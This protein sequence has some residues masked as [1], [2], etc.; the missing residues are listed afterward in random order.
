MYIR[1]RND[2]QQLPIVLMSYS[3]ILYYFIYPLSEL[4]MD[5]YPTTND[6]CAICYKWEYSSDLNSARDAEYCD[7]QLNCTSCIQ[8]ITI[9][10]MVVEDK[11]RFLRPAL[12]VNHHHHRPERRVGDR[13]FSQVGVPK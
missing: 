13:V 9:I 2:T 5:I 1:A 7:R 3:K 8:I 10:I 12:A 4:K 6:L 11:K